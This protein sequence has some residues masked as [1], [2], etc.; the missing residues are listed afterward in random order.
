MIAVIVGILL[1]VVAGAF[2][3][4]GVKFVAKK[5]ASPGTPRHAQAARMRKE[6]IAKSRTSAKAVTARETAALRDESLRLGIRALED[7][8]LQLK[9]D[10]KVVFQ[11]ILKK[12]RFES[13]EAKDRMD[14]VLGSAGGV[15]LEINGKII[16]SLGKRGQVLKNVQI[17]RANGLQVGK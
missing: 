16:P 12:G 13:W 11:N 6:K 17:T 14:L 5:I 15:Q 4:I 9:A 2:L 7:C 8:W 3:A 10:N 1:V